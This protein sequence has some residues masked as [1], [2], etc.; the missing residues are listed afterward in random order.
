MRK[1]VRLTTRRFGVALLLIIG[2]I[3]VILMAARLFAGGESIRALILLAVGGCFFGG[4]AGAWW[5]L[6]KP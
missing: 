5:A 6:K 3:W 1:V 2:A 4:W